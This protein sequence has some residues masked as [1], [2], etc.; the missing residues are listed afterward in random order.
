MGKYQYSQNEYSRRYGRSPATI[1]DYIKRGYP[2]DD[3]P[4]MFRLIKVL[5]ANRRNGGR[6]LPSNPDAQPPLEGTDGNPATHPG[7]PGDSPAGEGKRTIFHITNDIKEEELLTK[8]FKRLTLEGKMIDR[9]KVRAAGLKIGSTLD[10]ELKRLETDM[11][12]TLAGLDAASL[13]LKLA[14]YFLTLRKNVRKLLT[15]TAVTF[16]LESVN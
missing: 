16:D 9:E 2:L 3:A 13:Q 1:R 14:S 7:T 6:M 11:P 5:E 4:E 10:N 8:R 12:G 15:E